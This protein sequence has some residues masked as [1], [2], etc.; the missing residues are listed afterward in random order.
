MKV[1]TTSSLMIE[2]NG[3]ESRFSDSEFRLDQQE[4]R[5]RYTLV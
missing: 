3:L 2:F 5:L 1:N 4:K